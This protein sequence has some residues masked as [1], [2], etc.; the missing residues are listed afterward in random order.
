ML[1]ILEEKL[2]LGDVIVS[3]GNLYCFRSLFEVI[4]SLFL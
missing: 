4:M 2:F 1:E 3:F